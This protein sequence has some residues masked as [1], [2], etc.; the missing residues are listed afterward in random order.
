MRRIKR[1]RY[2]SV[3]FIAVLAL[4]ALS[5]L[6]VE[7]LGPGAEA[8][9][10]ETGT[11]GTDANNPH[12]FSLTSPGVRAQSE[13]EICIFC[14]T[15]HHARTEASIINAPLWNH[16]LSSQTYTVRVQGSAWSNAAIGEGGTILLSSPPQP[17]GASRL[18]LSCHDG[19][20]SI[21]AIYSK[22]DI[23]MA[24]TCLDSSGNPV[25]G[26]SGGALTSACRAWIGTD[27]RTKHVV[28]IPMNDDLI[29]ASFANCASQS[30]TASTQ[31]QYP[32]NDANGQNTVLLRPVGQDKTFNGNPGITRASIPGGETKYKSGY[33]YGV[34][35]STCHD[36]HDWANT[37]DPNTQGYR[38]LVLGFNNLCVTCHIGC[39]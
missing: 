33:H 18:C 34:Q 5:F 19:S 16:E 4:W 22:A 30:G 10:G 26:L 28:S 15:P 36:P 29:A 1:D 31:L 21:G 13:D 17:D 25:S 14:H 24:S 7:G 20:I 11:L 27:L 3:V 2:S 37:S 8:V 9:I 38:F 35:C 23:S 6:A 32:W 12:N 39:P